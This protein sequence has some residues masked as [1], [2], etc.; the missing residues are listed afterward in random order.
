MPVTILPPRARPKVALTLPGSGTALGVIA[1]AL[2]VLEEEIDF[3]VVGGTS[4]G[5]LIALGLAYGLTPQQI[6]VLLAT[7]LQ[8]KDL[9]DKGWPFDDRPGLF[10]GARIEGFLK[11]TFKDARLGDLPK[12]VRVCVW[13]AWTRQPAVLDSREHPDVLVWR[14]ARATMAI[15]FFFDLVRLREDNARLYGDGGLVLNVP[16]GL[17]DDYKDIPTLGLRFSDQPKTFDVRKLIE[18]GG[19]KTDTKRVERVTTWS[20]LVPAAAKSALSTASSSWPS[21]KPAED[22]VRGF[23]E[24]VLDTDADPFAFGLPPTEI[25]RRRQHGRLSAQRAKLRL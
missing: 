6:S 25:A 9:L 16:N 8:R 13:D 17:F 18:V 24:L 15:Q 10:R 3:E 23:H 19:G 12:H 20:T 2:E 1:G 7:F 14:A 11:D 21:N 5:G 4:G 22:P